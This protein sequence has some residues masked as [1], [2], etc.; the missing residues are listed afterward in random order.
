[1]RAL[2]LGPGR[3]SALC[4]DALSPA[5]VAAR[6]TSPCPGQAPSGS[7]GLAVA[8]RATLRA[9]PLGRTGREGRATRTPGSTEPSGASADGFL[10]SVLI[11]SPYQ[12]TRVSLFCSVSPAEPQHPG[13]FV[14]I[15]PAVGQLTQVL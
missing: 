8:A 5:R 11:V 2:C 14:C 15:A 7:G 3:H 1:M 10:S 6:S 13:T 9:F 12:L 4:L